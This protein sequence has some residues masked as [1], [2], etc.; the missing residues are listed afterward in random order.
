[1]LSGP[2]TQKILYREFHDYGDQRYQRLA[3][4]SVPHIYNLRKVAFIGFLAMV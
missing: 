4:L 2:A 1:M 3:T